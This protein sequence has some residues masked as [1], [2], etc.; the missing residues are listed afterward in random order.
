MTAADIGDYTFIGRGAQIGPNPVSIGRY[1][2]IGPEVLIGPNRHPVESASTSPVFYSTSW[3][4]LED[5]R[6]EFNR[7]AVAIGNDVWIGAR[8]MVLPGVKIADGAVVAAGAIV[9]RDVGPY[10]IVGG[11]P[12]RLLRLRFDKSLITKLLESEWWLRD[13]HEL[14]LSAFSGSYVGQTLVRSQN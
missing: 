2:S 13:M 8:A 14:D 5:R 7:V 3:G 12:A 10:M 6:Q 9:T 1:C 11:V 4:Q